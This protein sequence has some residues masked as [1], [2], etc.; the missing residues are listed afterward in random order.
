MSILT[1]IL[2]LFKTR[3]I[4]PRKQISAELQRKYN[5]TGKTVRTCNFCN[6][7][8]NVKFFYKTTGNVCKK[9]H[10]K[11]CSQAYKDKREFNKIR[12]NAFCKK[13]AV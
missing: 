4:Y 11:R 3:T 10:N 8:K 6:K 9:C 13:N 1:N 5:G 12:E 7:K 2:G